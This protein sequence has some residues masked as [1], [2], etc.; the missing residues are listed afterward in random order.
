MPMLWRA[1]YTIVEIIK[2]EE[3]DFNLSEFS[4]LYSLVT[5]DS[6]RYLFKAK[7]RQPLPILK[8]TQH[9]STWKNQFFF[10]RRDSIPHGNSLPKKWIVMCAQ[11]F[12]HK[13][14]SKFGLDDINSMLY[15]CSIQKEL[16]KG[17][18]IPEPKT[19]T[20]RA[21]VGSKRKKSM[22]SEDDAFE[23]ERQFHEFVIEKFAH[24]KAHHEKSLSEMEE[25]LVSL[26]SIVAAKDNTISKL[27]KDV[28]ALKKQLFM[29]EMETNKAVM[30]AI[31]EAKVFVTCTVLQAKIRMA[32]EAVDPDFDRSAWD[33]ASWKQTLLHLGGEVEPEPVKAADARSSGAKETAGGAGGEAGGD[34]VADGEVAIVGYEGR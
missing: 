33:V 5:H 25:N 18:S 17:Q 30:E 4:Y 34:E 19:M 8:T 2:A 15:P 11:R 22:E 23:V 27:E 12:A 28:K 24:V 16:A 21:K 29:A 3:L 32:E 14:A 31:D 26:R 13:S 7:P 6:S 9:D 10:V 20:T 1:L